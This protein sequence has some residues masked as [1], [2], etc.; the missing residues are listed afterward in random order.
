MFQGFESM[1]E[2]C[3][4]RVSSSSAVRRPVLDMNL[5]VTTNKT[6]IITSSFQ[7][8]LSFNNQVLFP[9]QSENSTLRPERPRRQSP[10]LR[11]VEPLVTHQRFLWQYPQD[12]QGEACGRER[13]KVQFTFLLVLILN[14][15]W[16][17]FITYRK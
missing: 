5:Y 12:I 6:S 11:L 8:H 17:L 7:C 2:L 9:F 10:L 1:S 3:T 16:K 13:V 14:D 4:W 15:R